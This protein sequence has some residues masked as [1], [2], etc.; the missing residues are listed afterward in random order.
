MD[1][2]GE[3]EKVDLERERRWPGRARQ[4]DIGTKRGIETEIRGPGDRRTIGEQ[5]RAHGVDANRGK[6]LVRGADVRRWPAQF[7]P[8]ASTPHHVAVQVEWPAEQHARSLHAALEHELAHFRARADEPVDRDRRDD[9][10][11]HSAFGERDTQGLHGPRT[12]L[13][14]REVLADH[15]TWTA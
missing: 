6:E 7:A 2:R 15:S 14:V 4:C 10:Q 12:R 9:V 3:D 11:A 8:A 1:V 13:S 5:A